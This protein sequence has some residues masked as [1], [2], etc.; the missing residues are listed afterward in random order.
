MKRNLFLS[1]IMAGVLICGN[2]EAK[3]EPK[4]PHQKKP[5][6]APTAAAPVTATVPDS[7]TTVLLLAGALLV[8][9][10]LRRRPS[11]RFDEPRIG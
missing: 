5:D 10:V 6:P 1:L 7:G 3:H 9:A 2:A 4:P 11:G 8:L